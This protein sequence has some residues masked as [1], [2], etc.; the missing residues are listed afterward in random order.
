[1]ILNETNTVPTIWAQYLKA[2]GAI[3]WWKTA[4]LK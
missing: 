1:M 2:H 3:K 4:E